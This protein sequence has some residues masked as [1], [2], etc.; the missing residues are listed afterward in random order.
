VEGENLQ[1]LVRKQ[2]EIIKKLEARIAWLEAQVVELTATIARLRKGFPQ[3]IKT[4]LVRHR[5]TKNGGTKKQSG[6]ASENRR[7]ERPQETRTRS[8]P[9]DQVDQFIE[10]TLDAC[11][12]CGGALHEHEQVVT[13]QQIEIIEKPYVVKEYHCHTY[14]AP[15][16]KRHIRRGNR[17]KSAAGCFRRG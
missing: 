1:E 17:K 14:T 3:F 15:P 12:V 11:P 6:Q 8:V 10:A 16:V 9:P 13:K 4:A 5:K 7:A 2:A